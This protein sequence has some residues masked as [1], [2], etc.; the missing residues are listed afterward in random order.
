MTKKIMIII[1]CVFCVAVIVASA[2]LGPIAV[3][4]YKMYRAAVDAVPLKEKIA[5]VQA[6]ESYVTADEIANEYLKRVVEIED[7]RFYSHG[8]FD[9]ISLAR[10]LLTN[11]A[12]GKTAIGGS[13][14]TQ[15][16]AKNLYFTQERIYERKVAELLVAFELERELTKDEILEL[17]CNIVYF[18]EGCYGIK[19][20]SM[21]YFGILPEKLDEHQ[22]VLLV[23]TLT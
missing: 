16:V 19:E 9:V 11:V 12:S 10:A 5:Q 6:D 23:R 20:A 7:H 3:R 1:L 22:A 17:Y 13:T 21:H 15:Q 18:G 2:V 8:A 14:I 4:G